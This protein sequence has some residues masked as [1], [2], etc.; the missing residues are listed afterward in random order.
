MDN[1]LL[2]SDDSTGDYGAADSASDWSSS[3]KLGGTC[4]NEVDR[5]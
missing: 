5:T 3:S 2:L 1:L 4:S